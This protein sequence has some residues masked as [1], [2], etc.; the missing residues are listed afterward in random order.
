[1]A[2][3]PIDQVRKVLN[4]AKTQMPANKIMMGQNLYGF[5]WKVPFKQGTMA[6]ALSSQ[7]ATELAVQN[8]NEILF[9]MKARAPHYRYTEA[10]GQRHEVWFEDARS[11][12][13]K[14]N[15]MKEEG[16]RGISYWKLGLPFIQN[17]E[18]L[19]ENFTIVKKA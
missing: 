3:S 13:A 8:T 4:Y 7:A 15:L 19:Q 2:V 16:I 11:I 18:L 5:D 17:W 10:N 9:D 6:K 12:Q 14:F 1:M